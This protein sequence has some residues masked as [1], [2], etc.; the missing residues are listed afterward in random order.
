M[1]EDEKSEPGSAMDGFVFV[2]GGTSTSR[3]DNEMA[4]RRADADNRRVGQDQMGAIG[5]RGVR[6]GEAARLGSNRFLTE[7]TPRV[8][9]LYRNKDKT[10]RQECISELVEVESKEQGRLDR[11]FVM[12]CPR[13]VARGVPQGESQV[14]VR[15]S[16][17]KFYL[18]DSEGKKNQI[19][20]VRDPIS[21]HPAPV[22]IAGTIYCEEIL[23]CN[24]YNCDWAVKIADSCVDEV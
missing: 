21:G 17:R 12:V 19:V 4:R 1:S 16:H 2:K 18:D 8:V 6:P 14:I 9:L 13:C 10:V 22:L 11:L 20:V 7:T 5:Q 23:R 3:Y 24:N 15:S